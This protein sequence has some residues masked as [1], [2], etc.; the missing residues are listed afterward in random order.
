MTRI[1][2]KNRQLISEERLRQ[3]AEELRRTDE[4]RAQR[5]NDP[6]HQARKKGLVIASRL[7][8]FAVNT[9][10]PSDA[11]AKNI[12]YHIERQIPI[13]LVGFWGEGGKENLDQY[14]HELLDHLRQLKDLIGFEYKPSASI[15]LV[16]ANVHGHFN[17]YSSQLSERS[18]YLERIREELET[19]G[20]SERWLS[21]LYEKYS[22]SLPDPSDPIDPS[23]ET[24]AV[25]MKNEQIY[26][27]SAT[28]HYV[29][30][31]DETYSAY[32]YVEMRLRERS[33]LKQEFPDSILFITGTKQAAQSLMPQ[34]VPVLYLKKGPAWF[35]KEDK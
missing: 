23:S 3:I 30:D 6:E 26:R 5:Q 27:R 8:E 19:Y 20:M 10:N 15:I 24:Y 35:K 22:I 1:E 16:L 11:L 4:L 2:T 12:A 28:L 7:R 14:D 29:G 17:G 9:T 18:P 13:P 33:M 32:R 25:L 21:D 34:G 31:E